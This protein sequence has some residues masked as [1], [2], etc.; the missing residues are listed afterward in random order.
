MSDSGTSR[1]ITEPLG[2]SPL[3]LAVQTGRLPA[4]IRLRRPSSPQEWSEHASRVR[5]G[6]DDGWLERIRAAL[7]PGGAAAKRLNQ[8]AGERG[9]VVTTGQQPGLFGGPVYTLSKALSALA[10]A[11]SLEKQLGVPVAPVFWAATDD[12][13]FLEAK[14]ASVADADGLHELSLAGSPPPGTPMSDVPLGNVGPLVD[15]LLKASGSAAHGAFFELA[16]AAFTGERTLGDAY[17]RLLRG[18]LEP[19]G[20]A[21]LDASHPS[22]RDAARP[23]LLSALERAADVTRATAECA[24]AI[25]RA[26]F[27]PQVEDDRGLALVFV[28]EKGIKRRISISEA[29]AFL[30]DAVRADLSPNVLLR[31]VVERTILPTAAY[32]AGPGELAYFTQANAVARALGRDDVVGVPRW[33]CTV[34]EP[35]VERALRRLGVQH[36]ELKDLHGLERRLATAALPESVAAAW[37]RLLEQV[38]GAVREVGAA[39]DATALMPPTVIEGLERSLS[40]R[41]SRAERRLIAAAKRRDEQVRRDLE[42]ASAGLY[43]LGNRQERVLNY[44]PMLARAGNPLLDAM[45]AAAAVHATSLIGTERQAPAVAR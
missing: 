42:V 29:K 2:G 35:F 39:V 12:A 43:P 26:G 1:V 45:R 44:I 23:V 7:T 3:S 13:D 9:I 40:H 4:E 37:K 11:D 31:P 33:S 28:R 14:S 17:V 6:V 16:R 15:Q 38:S 8:V 20:I 19:L 21:V 27:E 25:R 5:S 24:A 34:I 36:H 32:V 41:L 10:L 18:L 22:S 30:G